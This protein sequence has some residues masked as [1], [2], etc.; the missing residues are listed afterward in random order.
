[1]E[2]EDI[3]A[4]SSGP[5]VNPNEDFTVPS[6]QLD[7]PVVSDEELA[8]YEDYYMGQDM[9]DDTSIDMYDNYEVA[10]YDG[11][12]TPTATKADVVAQFAEDKRKLKE[13]NKNLK[14]RRN[15]LGLQGYVKED[16]DQDLLVTALVDAKD[17]LTK[18]IENAPNTLADHVE[19]R[20]AGY[21]QRVDMPFKLFDKWVNNTLVESVQTTIKE[22]YSN[23]R[24]S[25]FTLFDRTLNDA[26]GTTKEFI[27]NLEKNLTDGSARKTDHL[28]G[29]ENN[30]S[31]VLLYNIDGTYNVNTVEAMQGAA[32]EYLVQDMRNLIG[33][34]RTI[35][36]VAELF[37]ISADQVTPDLYDLL[38][39]GGVT[40]RM[41]AEGIGSKVY[42]NLGLNIDSIDAKNA[43][44]TSLGMVALQGMKG[45]LVD[46]YRYSG[47]ELRGNPVIIKGTPA[48]FGK[49]KKIKGTI[50]YFEE[51]LGVEIDNVRSYRRTATSGNRKVL[52]HRAEFQEAPKDHSDAVNRLEKTGFKPN[53]GV[54][55]LA[56]MFSDKDGAL[57]ANKL[58]KHILGPE[59][60]GINYDDELSYAAK[61]EALMRDIRFYNEALADVGDGELFF[62]WFIARNHRIHLDSNTL[63][64]QNDKNLARWLFT[65][66]N[67]R[68]SINKS[69]IDAVLNGEAT[70]N[71]EA[72]M[73]AYAIVQAFDGAKDVISVDKDNEA[74]VIANAKSLLQD[75]DAD[76]LMSM[77]KEASHVG[78]A[79]LALA[80]IR[81]YKANDV[82]NSDM[83][84]EVDGLTNG[85]AFRALQ[86]PV[87]SPNSP[88]TPTEWN[89]K[90]GF[91]SEGS[92]F[93]ALESMNGARALGQEDVYISVGGVFGDKLVAARKTMKGKNKKWVEFFENGRGLPNFSD[94]NDESLKK[95]V[96]NLMKSPVMI[97][98]YAAGA[99]KIASG[100]VNDQILGKG[101]L[102]GKGLLGKLTEQKQNENKEIVYVITKQDL[103]NHF[104]KTL[105][106]TY[107]NARVALA[108]KS[109]KDKS[110][111]NIQTLMKDLRYA[112]SNLYVEPITETLEELF[113]EQTVV[114][115]A[116][117]DASMF[118]YE[119]F[120]AIY[121]DWKNAN[122][123]AT[124]EDKIDFLKEKASILPGVK[125][126]NSD[127]QSN[128]ITF[129]KSVLEEST[130]NV[131]LSLGA[132]K[133]GTRT[134]ER[135]FGQPGVAAAVLTVLGLDSS[136]LARTINLHGDKGFLPVHDAEVLGIGEHRGVSNYN[137][138]F[139]DIN[140]SYSIID[141]FVNAVN[142]IRN[143][144]PEMEQIVITNKA[145]EPVTFYDM[146]A[147]LTN[148][149]DTV[150]RARAEI[151]SRNVKTGQ[152]G[153]PNGT[154]VAINV[155][156]R[157]DAA[158][159]ELGKMSETI[160]NQF[161]NLTMQGTLGKKEHQVYLKRLQ[162]MLEG[163]K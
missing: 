95:F 60:K 27:E 107:H 25:G 56:E 152:M 49:L 23:L 126:A 161:N 67:S 121:T 92:E 71:L 33:A 98:N 62:D 144:S 137:Q 66:T 111:P 101:Y 78:H 63:N 113:S 123:K 138:V 10:S 26:Q 19:T 115:R 83:V 91:V 65:T 157:K 129:L 158:I 112:I 114:N 28:K 125:G 52:I 86:Y 160:L 140:R 70:G 50:N 8:S 14:D 119:H 29:L 3:V 30:P 89:E 87:K 13:L 42:N 147:V 163:C 48:I 2:Q 150:Q 100:L 80:N 132:N 99:S 17:A 9:E 85:F 162:K 151:F 135:T 131:Q 11:D 155:K 58:A 141:E 38:S 130:N 159:T 133:I 139:Y 39:D 76:T 43:M 84:L 128:K 142:G 73:F 79:A 127:D 88:F 72:V 120:K 6:E 45:D 82:I 35:D 54:A 156:E 59:V 148:I 21:K 108:T 18:R 93:Y 24:P 90:I 41:A 32:Y 110:D 31:A 103:V 81:K 20:K 146:L 55:V 74:A 36:E 97:F 16:I 109:Y 40:L 47:S 69:D 5:A 143:A 94:K 34:D 7:A 153:G 102:S 77:A 75:T 122:P 117:T 57:D 12:V 105:G 44:I 61:K 96:R 149:N 51:T 68:V 145:G 136:T 46:I 116:I 4:P 118:M 15:E 53:D 106:E 1:M 37:N 104:G 124:E 154:M 64:P 22:L 134:V